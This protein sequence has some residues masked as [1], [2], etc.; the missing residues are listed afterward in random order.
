MN[1]T[2]IGEARGDKMDVKCIV[3][4]VEEDVEGKWIKHR[5]GGEGGGGGDKMDVKMYS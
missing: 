5:G 1:N 4:V 3:K 2:G